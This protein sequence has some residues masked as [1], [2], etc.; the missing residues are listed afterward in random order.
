MQYDKTTIAIRERNLADLGDLAMHVVAKYRGGLTV[1]MML[2]VG[3]LMLMNHFLLAWMLEGPLQD[4]ACFRYVWNMTML[5]LC[6][7]QIATAFATAYLG[8]VLFNFDSSWKQIIFDTLK[9]WRKLLLSHGI[10][11]GS[12]FVI[13]AYVYLWFDREAFFLEVL[14]VPLIVL[15]GAFVRTIRPF[16]TELIVL[17]KNPIRAKFG[18]EVSLGTRSKY[19]HSVILSDLLG[20]GLVFSAMIGLFGLAL[21]GTSLQTFGNFQRIGPD[22][23]LLTGIIYPVCLW[24]AA[25]FLFVI[26]FLSYL[27]VR[28][29]QEGW[30]IELRLKAIAIRV[31]ETYGI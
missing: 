22:Q 29:R 19:L 27:D 9:T 11:R 18:N 2:A 4:I 20:R 6:E 21:L 24:C 5:V 17:E 10:Y 8:G 3:P 7:S 13:L 30:E 28:T 23:F 12:F 1:S 16:I 31:R 14:W 15:W 26:R 25:T